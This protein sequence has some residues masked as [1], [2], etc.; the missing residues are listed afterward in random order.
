MNSGVTASARA[1]VLA[2]ALVAAGACGR[3]RP[4]PPASLLLVTIDTLRADRVGCYGHREAHTPYLDSLCAEGVAFD[5][6][7]AP[8]PVTL[9]SHAT[10]FTSLH[11]AAHGLFTNATGALADRFE[12]LAEALRPRVSRA[13][14]VVGSVVLDARF[15]LGQ[16]FDDYDDRMPPAP[17]GRYLFQRERSAG[18]VAEEASAW[19]REHAGRPFLL[20]V[21]FF[22]PHFPYDPPPP[23]KERLTDSYDAEIAAADE[24]LGRVLAALAGAGATE[25]TLVVVAGDHG[26]DLGEHGEA[27]HGVFLYDSTLRIP[28]VFRYPRGLAGG[29][30]VPALVRLVDLMPTVL[31]LFGLPVPPGAQGRSLLPLLTGEAD[32]LGLDVF[33]ESRLPEIQYGWARLAALRE[34]GWLYVRA[35][36]EEVYDVRSDPAQKRNVAA[37]QAARLAEMR[38]RL[39]EREAVYSAGPEAPRA[40]ISEETRRQIESLGYVGGGGGTA[41][42][43]GPPRPDPKRRVEQLA[44]IT[45]A[46]D[47]VSTSR[48]P[49]AEALLRSVLDVDP[50]SPLGLR[51]HARSLLMLGREEEARGEY[52]RLLVV[53]GEDGEVLNSLGAIDM[54]R[55]RLEEAERRFRRA[56]EVSPGDARA[57]NNLAFILAQSGRTGE[58]VGMLE[59]VIRD[60]PLFLDAV[61]NL[62][63][64]RAELG[65]LESAE[66]LLR[67][68]LE[69]AGGQPSVTEPLQ[70]ALAGVLERTGRSAEAISLYRELLGPGPPGTAPQRAALAALRRLGAAR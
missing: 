62:A 17:V 26:E 64:L 38:H 32:D 59:Q 18:Q 7:F 51:L 68:A 25:R 37:V 19:L 22:D 48:A 1:L 67:R 14:A 60:D 3:E 4:Q 33:C 15:G 66:N 57:R 52:E 53:A 31:D 16:G 39:A 10:I 55:G 40:A 65:E 24:G 61:L 9:P 28:L 11:P 21:H 44:A 20:W 63:L 47:L 56:L 2:A 49:E 54:R 35:P 41:R 8:A 23:W 27:T 5:G 42:R 58:A 13:G 50:Q 6:A 46:G 12:T 43:E 45:R 34:R 30:R 29:R 69:Q 70:L 36:E